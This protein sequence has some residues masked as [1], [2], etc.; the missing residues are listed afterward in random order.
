MGLR[1]ERQEVFK[2]VLYSPFSLCTAG[3]YVVP[4][5]TEPEETLN[6]VAVKQFEIERRLSTC[7]SEIGRQK[8][9]EAVAS[10]L[11]LRKMVK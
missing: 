8:A 5:K 4:L 3:T 9:V 11:M 2:L 6:A 7:W 1:V 10:A